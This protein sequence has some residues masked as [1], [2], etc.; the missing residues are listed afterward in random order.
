MNRRRIITRF[1]LLGSIVAAFFIARHWVLKR[2]AGAE[3]IR[4]DDEPAAA[5][6]VNAFPNLTIE[7]PIGLTFPPDGTNR[8]A[9]ISQFGS[10][11]IFPNDPDVEEPSEMLNIRKKVSYEDSSN[12][13][14]LLGLAFHPQF[15]QNRQFFV[16]YTTKEHVNL[17]SR[18][19]MSPDNPNRADPASEV[20]IFRSP[21]KAS[22]NHNGGTLIFAPEGYLY[23]A[24]GDG[25]PV[26]DPNGNGQNVE[27]VLGKILRID[28][29]RQDPGLNYAIPKDNSFVGVAGARG[30][31]WALGLRNVW[32]MAFDRQANRLWA[33]DVGEDT[34][35]EIDLIERG[36]NYGW[37][38]YEGFRKFVPKGQPPPAPPSRIIGKLTEP[39]FAYNHSIGNCVVGGAVYRGKNVPEL[40]GAYLFAD[41]VTGHV[42]ALRCDERSGVSTTVQAIRGPPGH[43]DM[44]VCSFGED[45]S[46]ELY[47][48]TS[49]GVINRF[50]P[51]TAK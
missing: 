25:G 47:V 6:F 33:A 43:A 49:A 3:P 38:M 7:R 2:Y 28:I 27:T 17:L 41:Y 45:E 8:I 29:D 12:E 46:G 20:E 48:M 18:F 14:G 30:E 9:V 35:E 44:P 51:R 37:N 23:M 4:I 40:V 16:Y 36:G 50:V 22:G 19:T 11:L 21:R 13:D 1:V 15:K 10:V 34:W 31:I 26:N 39:L 32:R 42:Y 24:I 5:T